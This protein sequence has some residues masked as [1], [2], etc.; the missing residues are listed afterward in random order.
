[1][2]FCT[3]GVLLLAAL[4][5]AGCG[6]RRVMLDSAIWCHLTGASARIRVEAP[7]GQAEYT[8]ALVQATAA[9]LDGRAAAA[10]ARLR[11]LAVRYIVD[12]AEAAN[13][14]KARITRFKGKSSDTHLWAPVRGFARCRRTRAYSV[15]GVATPLFPLAPDAGPFEWEAAS[16]AE[17]MTAA[18]AWLAQAGTGE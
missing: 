1:M 10:D 2:R 16:Y 6:E 4:A 9:M 14:G 13:S 18:S 11:R 7:R 17:F 5:L 8:P 12:I 15:A 3:V